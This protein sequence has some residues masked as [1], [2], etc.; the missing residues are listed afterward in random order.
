MVAIIFLPTVVRDK[1][2]GFI[3]YGGGGSGLTFRMLYLDNIE[4]IYIL[5]ICFDEC[6]ENC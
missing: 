6:V 4:T 1:T 5:L 2:A 3:N